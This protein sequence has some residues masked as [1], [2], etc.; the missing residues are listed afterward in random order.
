MADWMVSHPAARR[1]AGRSGL[2]ATVS[3]HMGASQGM[4]SGR[5]VRASVMV[6]T[7]RGLTA[8]LSSVS[9]RYSM[10]CAW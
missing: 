9:S 7:R 1:R 8:K 2:L 10:P 3:W 6:R 4:R 5:A